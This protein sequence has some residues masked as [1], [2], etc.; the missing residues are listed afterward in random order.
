MKFLSFFISAVFLFAYI[1]FPAYA[2]TNDDPIKIG[3]AAPFTGPYSFLA[4][5]MLQAAEACVNIINDQG[6]LLGKS[7]KLVARDDACDRY[8]ADR[9]AYEFIKNDKVMAV[10]GH[11]PDLAQDLADVYEESSTIFLIP[12]SS[13]R[14]SHGKFYDNGPIFELSPRADRLGEMVAQEI[15]NRNL[16]G[17]LGVIRDGT[18][19]SRQLTSSFEDHLTINLKPVYKASAYNPK[20]VQQAL[21]QSDVVLFTTNF[22]ITRKIIESLDMSNNRA[23]LVIIGT[24]F[25]RPEDW[26]GF[27]T[28]IEKHK[29]NVLILSPSLSPVPIFPTQLGEE[30]IDLLYKKNTQLRLAHWFVITAFELLAHSINEA[31]T[32]NTRDV[33]YA[34]R[35]FPK[36]TLLGSLVSGETGKVGTIKQELSAPIDKRTLTELALLPK[37]SD[38]RRI[39]PGEQILW[40][41]WAEDS[42]VDTDKPSFKP[43][44]YLRPD[45]YYLFTLDLSGVSYEQKGG[46]TYTQRIEQKLADTLK[47]W[48]DAG[49][50]D[51]KYQVV[52]IGDSTCFEKPEKYVRE[53]KVNLNNM[54]RF[55]NRGVDI[56]RD[57][58]AIMRESKDKNPDFVFGR[59]FFRIKTKRELPEG[60]AHISLSLWTNG[61]PVDEIST[62]IRVTSGKEPKNCNGIGRSQF[63]LKGV[64]SLYVASDS[65]RLPEAALHFLQLNSSVTCIFR[66][67]DWPVNKFLSWPLEYNLSSLRKELSN[68]LDAYVATRDD[69]EQLGKKGGGLYNILFPPDQ[70]SVRKQFEEFIKPYLNDESKRTDYKAPSIFV[71]MIQ[72]KTDPPLLIPLGLLAVKF[73]EGPPEFLGFHFR[74]ESPLGIQSYESSNACISRWVTVFPPP[75]H[76]DQ[77]LRDA[78]LRLT[79]QIE[80]WR[81][82]AWKPFENMRDFGNW[83]SETQTENASTA[84]VILSHH[85]NDRITFEPAELVHSSELTRKFSKPSIVVLSGCGT[86]SP[87]SVG[88][89]RRF[90]Q[91]G[92]NTVIAT[93]TEVD[94]EM[95]GDFLNTFSK[96]LEGNKNDKKFNV[97]M[98]YFKAI[99][100]LRKITPPK[101][102]VPYGARVLEFTFLGNGNTRLC[103]PQK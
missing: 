35:T 43:V 85:T 14:E 32:E 29:I 101:G 94:P 63:S 15:T 55:E 28:E 27:L 78:A 87:G 73:D 37:R 46:L 65:S 22:L 7:V 18:Y 89:V 17:F 20:E 2:Q 60:F 71:R 8:Q 47:K 19:F 72:E 82:Q 51:P 44:S 97:A 86:A 96:V 93:S 26:A 23:K 92:I 42:P 91:N 9:V 11:C 50:P 4:L 31:N 6:G 39:G 33:S 16:G 62:R 1:T 54:R 70:K 75:N 45:K 52:I 41:V 66:R 68:W 83:V 49:R 53:L 79:N 67:N 57:P 3:L 102:K 48:R 40:N 88:F 74:I 99:Q 80:I 36:P 69:E 12:F 24:P 25:D 30:A 58:F 38:T 21:S 81:E 77:A 76:P 13:N 98:A 61:K 95:A 103:P 64:D 5:E 100:L 34:F 56:N 84:I 10:I 59:V 90:N